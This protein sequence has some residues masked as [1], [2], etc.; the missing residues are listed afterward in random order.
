MQVLKLLEGDEDTVKW[1]MQQVS[2]CSSDESEMLKD[3]QC[4]RSSLQSHL[5]VALLDV[6]DDSISMGSI[7]QGVSVEDYLKGRTSRS[8]SFD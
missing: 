7:E 1:A 3:E 2:S 4:Q 5:N 6:E 8:S